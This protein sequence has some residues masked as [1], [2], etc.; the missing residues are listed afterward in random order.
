MNASAPPP[1]RHGLVRGAGL[2]T[3]ANVLA[4]VG[5][6]V[7]LATL[8][9]LIPR[10]D[11]AVI[12]FAYLVVDV[13][14]ALGTLELPA[15]MIYFVSRFQDAHARALGVRTTVWLLLGSTVLALVVWA[16]GPMLA[17]HAGVAGFAAV[18]PAL[19]LVIL[20]DLPGQALPGLLLARRASG[21]YFIATITYS[22]LRFAALVVAAKLGA[23]ATLLVASLGFASVARLGIL[24]FWLVFVERGGTRPEGWRMVDLLRFSAP[25]VLSTLVGRLGLQFDKY[26]VSVIAPPAAFAAYAVG[27]FELP[28]VAGVAYSVTN[29]L[30]SELTRRASAG[31][32][33]GAGHLWHASMV[34]VATLIFPVFVFCFALAEP[35]MRLVFSA[36]YTDA[37]VPFRVL[38]CLLPLRLCGYGAVCR[39]LGE[40]TPVLRGSLAAAAVNLALAWP[41]YTLF[42]LAGPTLATVLGQVAAIAVLLSAIRRALALDLERILPWRDLGRAMLTALAAAPVLMITPFDTQ[43]APRVFV[44]AALFLPAYLAIG[45]ATGVVAT[46]DLRAL[47]Q[48][49]SVRRPRWTRP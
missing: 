36:T 44:G 22:G 45:H 23:S 19:A 12:L 38:L 11:L 7:L 8:T 30:M 28:L 6:L 21:T 14:G 43:D 16:L 48:V 34:K 25:I 26:L 32:T 40:S 5:N 10:E 39:A 1:D 20:L 31:D 47:G 27:A 29:A 13:V 4:G 41:L 17:D 42:G 49:F 24:T 46:A 37:A 33:E 2:T 15:A 35:L 3:L 9:R 18:L